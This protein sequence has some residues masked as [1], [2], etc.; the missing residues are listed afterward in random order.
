[1]YTVKK[2]QKACPMS[3]FHNIQ[4]LNHQECVSS[5]LQVKGNCKADPPPASLSIFLPHSLGRWG[6]N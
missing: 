3:E 5:V 6:R 4:N 2:S 1:M